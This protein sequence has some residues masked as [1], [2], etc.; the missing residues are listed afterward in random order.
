LYRTPF[1]MGGGGT[2][3]NHESFPTDANLR[4]VQYIDNGIRTDLANFTIRNENGSYIFDIAPGSEVLE[5]IA[6]SNYSSHTPIM[7]SGTIY[8]S[9]GYEGISINPYHG[10]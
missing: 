3:F 9:K 10:L 7:A 4:I 6:T 2:N 8:L 1:M 5:I